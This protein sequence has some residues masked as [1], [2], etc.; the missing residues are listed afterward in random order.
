MS[1]SPITRNNKGKINDSKCQNNIYYT[2][3]KN[4]KKTIEEGRRRS[5][6]ETGSKIW[7]R[8]WV[9]SGKTRIRVVAGKRNLRFAA[10]VVVVMEFFEERN[11]GEKERI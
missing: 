10:M 8:E 6:P 9:L 4:R 7:Q 5:A 2:I 1:F 3:S 11:N